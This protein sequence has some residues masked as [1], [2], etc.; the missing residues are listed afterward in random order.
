MKNTSTGILL[1][2]KEAKGVADI[3]RLIAYMDDCEE[4][5]GCDIV[6]ERKTAKRLYNRIQ[7]ILINRLTGN[8]KKETK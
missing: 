8:G 4:I 1:S 6:N 3:L 5:V 2:P 7:T